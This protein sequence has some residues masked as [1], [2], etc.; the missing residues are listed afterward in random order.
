[1]LSL[2]RIQEL[3]LSCAYINLGIL[4]VCF[5]RYDIYFKH[6]KTKCLPGTCSKFNDSKVKVF[7]NRV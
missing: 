4:N 3:N 1:M 2:E 5:R 6:F 7:Y